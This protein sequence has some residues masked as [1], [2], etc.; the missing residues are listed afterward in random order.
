MAIIVYPTSKN[1]LNIT[2]PDANVRL[3]LQGVSWPEDGFTARMLSDEEVTT[4]KDKAWKG[5]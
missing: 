3:T 1:A 5:E 4:D 2:H